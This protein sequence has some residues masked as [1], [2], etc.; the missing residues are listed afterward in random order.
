MIVVRALVGSV[1]LVW[2]LAG[3]AAVAAL[4]RACEALQDP[5][6]PPIDPRDA[7]YVPEDVEEFID[8]AG[9]VE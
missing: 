9:W 5:D 1:A 8:C 7:L 2:G 3:L 4:G 6:G